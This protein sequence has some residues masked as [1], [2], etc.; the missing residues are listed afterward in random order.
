MNDSVLQQQGGQ[1]FMAKQHREN[2]IRARKRA[3]QQRHRPAQRVKEAAA[4]LRSGDAERA[5]ALATG[6]LAVAD[7]PCS[8]AGG[9]HVVIEAHFRAAAAAM[10]PRT[11]LHHLD[12]AVQRA[13][14]ETRLR[15]HR[16]ITLWEL[17][18]IPEALPELQWLETQPVCR[19]GVAFLYQLACAA[20]GQPWSDQALSAAEAQTLRVLQAVLQGA[21]SAELLKQTA[22]S[23]WRLAAEAGMATPWFVENRLHLLCAQAHDLGQEGRWHELIALLQAHRLTEISDPALTEMLAVA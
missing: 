5:L 2:A 22:Q 20:T 21:N 4:A 7:A 3:Q 1:R 8:R 19:P 16:A 6:A 12:A 23:A 10:D 18:R 11:R 14:E 17:G 13:P 15:Y 9:G